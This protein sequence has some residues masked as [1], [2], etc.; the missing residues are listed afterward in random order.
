MTLR[1]ISDRDMQHCHSSKSTCDIGDPPSRAPTFHISYTTLLWNLNVYERPGNPGLETFMAVVQRTGAGSKPRI[2]RVVPKSDR[3]HRTATTD[4]RNLG[5]TPAATI[6]HSNLSQGLYPI[7][8]QSKSKVSQH[9]VSITLNTHSPIS[10]SVV[11]TSLNPSSDNT[12]PTKPSANYPQTSHDLSR[13]WE[14]KIRLISL[15]L[16]NVNSHLYGR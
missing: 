8:K 9:G 10:S 6:S 11:F 16:S 12:S 14:S 5:L 3:A 13:L 4:N 7:P 2:S 15:P 1:N